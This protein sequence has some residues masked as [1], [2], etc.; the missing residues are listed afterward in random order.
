MGGDLASGG[1]GAPVFMIAATRDPDGANLD[2]I[3]VVKG[4]LDKAGNLQERVYNVAMSDGREADGKGRVKPLESTVD[5][6]KA[7]YSNDSGA[8]E[9]RVLWQDPDF[10][11]ALRAVYYVR[12]LEIPTPRWTAYDQAFF[13]VNIP[14]HI[15]KEVQ[16]RAYTSP[17]WY[18]P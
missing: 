10:D 12:V 7:T 3:Q 17:I 11:S 14:D 4:W 6:E 1:E 13:G 2:R 8:A 18:T 9:L 5:P 15:P 16:N